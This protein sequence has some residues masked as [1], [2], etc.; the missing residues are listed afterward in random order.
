MEL[1]LAGRER[2]SC[3]IQIQGMADRFLRRSRRLQTLVE[4]SH[5]VQDGVFQLIH[6][7]RFTLQRF[8]FHHSEAKR[9]QHVMQLAELA[10]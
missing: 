9:E 8:I 1:I 5:H 6:Q 7:R 3:A 4:R 2:A 10:G